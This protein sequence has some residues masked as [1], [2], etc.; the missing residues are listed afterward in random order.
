MSPDAL[1][2]RAV[3]ERVFELG[4]G[5]I[6]P[7]VGTTSDGLVWVAT[8]KV[9]ER[10]FVGDSLVQACDAWLAAHPRVTP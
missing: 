1:M 8:S 4:L 10:R 3:A 7:R 2:L 6:R 9:D 5:E